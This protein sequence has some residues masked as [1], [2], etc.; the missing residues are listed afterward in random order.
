MGPTLF[1]ATFSL[2]I[3]SLSLATSPL[4]IFKILFVINYYLAHLLI[5]LVKCL[6]LSKAMLK[7]KYGTEEVAVESIVITKLDLHYL[8]FVTGQPEK[9]SERTCQR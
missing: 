8:L 9:A 1:L 5:K 6:P 4:S 3:P 7:D 2:K